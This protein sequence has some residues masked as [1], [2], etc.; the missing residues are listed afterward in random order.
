MVTYLPREGWI[1]GSSPKN[2]YVPAA[3]REGVVIHH[4]AT[5]KS[6]WASVGEVITFM[7]QLKGMRPD[8]GNDVPYNLV[9]FPMESTLLLV[10]GVGLYRKGAHCAKMNTTT[11]GVSFA[12]NFEENPIEAR[13]L[14]ALGDYLLTLKGLGFH[15]AWCKPHQDF[16]ATACPGKAILPHVGELNRRLT[17]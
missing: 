15:L 5:A 12:G 8:L 14:E 2:T 16:K 3:K 17:S 1:N 11:I 13:H 10:E 4:T 6:T 7:N 9:A